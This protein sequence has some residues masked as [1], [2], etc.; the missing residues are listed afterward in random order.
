MVYVGAILT[1]YW[2]NLVLLVILPPLD[3]KG[4]HWPSNITDF[5]KTY[6]L[7]II[8][9]ADNFLNDSFF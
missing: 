3:S 6:F 4:L 9:S 5:G 2:E 7:F 8:M 1:Q